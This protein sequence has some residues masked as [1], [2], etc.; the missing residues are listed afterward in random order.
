ME[1]GTVNRRVHENLQRLVSEGARD[2]ELAT[3]LFA[4][5]LSL[6]FKAHGKTWVADHFNEW[7]KSFA[8]TDARGFEDVVRRAG[9]VQFPTAIAA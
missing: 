1:I 7:G 6:A 4:Y 3:V 5:S 2:E 8:E 9:A